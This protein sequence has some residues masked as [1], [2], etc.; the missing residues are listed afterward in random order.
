MD[1]KVR[2]TASIDN[3]VLVKYLKDEIYTKKGKTKH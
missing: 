1:K 2:V 3:N